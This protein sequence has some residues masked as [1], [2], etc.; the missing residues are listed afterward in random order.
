M[1]SNIHTTRGAARI[2]MPNR[3]DFTMYRGFMQSCTP[4]LN[5]AA[6]REIEVELS[7][8]DYLDSFALDMLTLLQERA[9]SANK[10][11]SLL[12]PSTHA[13]QALRGR[14]NDMFNIKHTTVTPADDGIE[15][16]QSSRAPVQG[17]HPQELP[18]SAPSFWHM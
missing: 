8:V 13:S 11:L 7:A 5:N 12:S 3:F 16:K 9:K 1:L 2:A 18:D 17:K 4:L 14:F 10:S 15:Q 6:I